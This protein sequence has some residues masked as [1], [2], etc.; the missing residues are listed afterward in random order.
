MANS[1]EGISKAEK[2][3]AKH[4][5]G[6]TASLLTLHGRLNSCEAI[7]PVSIN[8]LRSGITSLEASTASADIDTDKLGD[9]VRMITKGLESIDMVKR[10]SEN[11]IDEL[12]VITRSITPIRE[13]IEMPI[14]AVKSSQDSKVFHL[15]KALADLDDAL[16]NKYSW[17]SKIIRNLDN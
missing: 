3:K 14:D 15:H 16:D 12:R 2:I 1:S 4:F 5:K 7:N 11:N 9:S 8:I 13:D 6:F 10:P 17:F